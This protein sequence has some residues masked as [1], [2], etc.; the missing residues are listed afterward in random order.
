MQIN[1]SLLALDPSQLAW[2]NG[3]A[4]SEKAGITKA[5]SPLM[6][7]PTVVVGITPDEGGADLLHH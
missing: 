3:G 5:Q 2:V 1:S 4:V 7:T 6:S